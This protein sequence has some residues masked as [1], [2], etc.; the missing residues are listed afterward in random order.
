MLWRKHGVGEVRAAL[1]VMTANYFQVVSYVLWEARIWKLSQEMPRHSLHC[2]Q[3]LNTCVK[4][5][6]LSRK[7]LFHGSFSLYSLHLFHLNF[8]FLF[9]FVSSSIFLPVNTAVVSKLQSWKI[10]NI[11]CEKDGRKWRCENWLSCDIESS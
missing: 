7:T 9:D 4:I 1:L 11:L 2:I 5:I 3:L 10:E 6:Y 8:C